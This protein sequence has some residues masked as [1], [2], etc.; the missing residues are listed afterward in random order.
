MR[1]AYEALILLVCVG[2]PCLALG[3]E[4]GQVSLQARVELAREGRPFVELTI[5]SVKVY[6]KGFQV[7]TLKVQDFDAIRKGPLQW[8]RVASRIPLRKVK[9][10][11]QVVEHLEPDTEG[12]VSSLEEIVALEDMP[13]S[14]TILLE[15]GSVFMITSPEG[16][17][18]GGWT[19]YLLLMT[20]TSTRYMWNRFENSS[21]EAA[22]LSMEPSDARQLYWLLEEGTGVIY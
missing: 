8:S 13:S 6:L 7:K 1:T 16:L 5:E 2:L 21:V 12:A 18:V 19:R 14:Y 9:K 20:R 22:I 17:G 3:Q 15:D 10:V 11:V 4:T